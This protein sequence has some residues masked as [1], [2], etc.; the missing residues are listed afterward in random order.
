MTFS[1]E[2]VVYS[3]LPNSA[4]VYDRQLDCIYTVQV[5]RN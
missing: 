4:N 2:I 3:L 1:R 5:V